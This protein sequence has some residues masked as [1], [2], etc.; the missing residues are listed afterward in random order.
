MA[1]HP[2]LLS[3]NFIGWSWHH[4]ARWIQLLNKTET[5]RW[6]KL[7][8]NSRKTSE[9]VKLGKYFSWNSWTIIFREF[10][11]SFR[12]SFGKCEYQQK[13][14]GK[15]F[16]TNFVKRKVVGKFSVNFRNIFVFANNKLFINRIARAVP[17]NT[18]PS[19]FTHF[20]TT[21]ARCV[22]QNLGLSIS[23]YGPCILLINSNFSAD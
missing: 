5:A 23:L 16:W 14:L 15:W 8:Q 2:A 21:Q 18:K 1:S 3:R 19:F 11:V 17:W 9:V 20:N 6:P 13:T 12:T 10:S 7:P 22:L 4:P